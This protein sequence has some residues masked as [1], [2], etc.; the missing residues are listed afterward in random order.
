MLFLILPKYLRQ[1]KA[2]IWGHFRFKY[3]RDETGLLSE[4]AIFLQPT[5]QEHTHTFEK[6]VRI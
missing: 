4:K 2:I 1:F 6:G 5:V 3:Y